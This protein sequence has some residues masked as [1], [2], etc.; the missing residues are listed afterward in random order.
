[1]VSQIGAPLTSPAVVAVKVAAPDGRPARELHGRTEAIAAC[2]IA[3]A[4][5]LVDDFVNGAIELF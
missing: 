1:M 4:P 3:R 2:H 5:L